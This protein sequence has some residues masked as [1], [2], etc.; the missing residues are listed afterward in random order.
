M[1]AARFLTRRGCHLCDDALRLLTDGGVEVD[2]VDIDGD[3]ELRSRFDLRVPVVLD[4][5]GSVIAE[6]VITE[7]DLRRLRR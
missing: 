4:A 1:A 2:V 7:A 5:T 6:G 3:D